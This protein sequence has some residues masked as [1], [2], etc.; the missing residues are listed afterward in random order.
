MELLVSTVVLLLLLALILTVTGSVGTTIGRASSRLDAFATARSAFDLVTHRLGQATLNPYY[1]YLDAQGRAASDPLY[2]NGGAATPFAPARYGRL[3]DLQFVVK[4]NVQAPGCGQEVYFVSPLASALSADTAAVSG[5]LN[6]GSFFVHYGT[7]QIFLPNTAAN[8]RARYRLMQAVQP[9]EKL[10]VFGS[11][12][13]GD[14]LWLMDIRNT[15]TT[16]GRCV[17]PLADNVLALTVWPRLSENEDSTGSR[18]TGDY[19]YDSHPSP[20]AESTGQPETANQLPPVVQVT[21][22]VLNEASAARL[23]G[24]G[25]V[26]P[27]MLS[28]ALVNADGKPKFS[29]STT[30][31]HQA[32][33]ND[34]S[35]HLAR[36]G[37]NFEIFSTAVSM[38]E[39]RWGIRPATH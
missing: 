9:T 19:T 18:L 2:Q 3:S 30:A 14:D 21:M 25:S 33:L 27:A 10:K 32:D 6:G 8:P 7:D 37:I 29:V 23:G 22:V 36:N 35:T 11:V 34:L 26:S 28:S 12:V 16:L 24:D 1:G 39:A 31:Q 4:T 15:P 20:S 5:L 38:R 13:M 17:S